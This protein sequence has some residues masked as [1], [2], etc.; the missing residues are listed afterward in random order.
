MS[1]MKSK[2]E[3]LIF[4]NERI[5]SLAENME[6]KYKTHSYHDLSRLQ[7]EKN[8]WIRIRRIIRDEFHP[9]SN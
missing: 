9:T 5:F 3:L 8:E 4:M 7:R 2:A 6:L 1:V